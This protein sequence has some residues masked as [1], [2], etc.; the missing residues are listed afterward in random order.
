MKRHRAHL[1]ALGA[2]DAQEEFD[3]SSGDARWR[4]D[5]TAG[6]TITQLVRQGNKGSDQGW[7][8]D[9]RMRF[10]SEEEWARARY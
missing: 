7:P 9:I 10:T 2:I 3:R 4:R 1:N 5:S 6:E 8:N